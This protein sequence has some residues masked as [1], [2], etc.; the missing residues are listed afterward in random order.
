MIGRHFSLILLPT[1]E[2]N[3][4][5]DYCFEDRT[6]DFMSLAQLQIV[7]DKVL[8]HMERKAIDALTI[9]WQGGEVMLLSPDWF[10]RAQ[11]L[12]G[13]AAAVRG[14]RVRHHLQSNM[15]G[16]TAAWNPIITEMFG[17]SVGTSMDFPN[18]YRKAR[19]H[20]PWHY[21]ALWTRHIR[22]ARDAGI[23]IG[24]IAI[25]NAATLERGAEAFYAYFVDELGIDDFQVNT[26]FSGGAP[27]EAKR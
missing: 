24:V 25:P 19:G 1:N 2:C 7:I 5:C 18:L 8:D 3:V 14:K 4:A 6:S 9:Y 20:P 13:E 23:H 22:A 27:T 17:S 15:I 11:A 16:Y 12:I 10:A 21:T 26:A